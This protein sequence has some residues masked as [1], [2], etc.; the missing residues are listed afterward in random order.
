MFHLNQSWQLLRDFAFIIVSLKKKKMRLGKVN[1]LRM[2]SVHEWRLQ[3]S[4]I[5]SLWLSA[6]ITIYYSIASWK[7]TPIVHDGGW[8]WR[9]QACMGSNL[10]APFSPD[11]HLH[12][13]FSFSDVILLMSPLPFKPPKI[14]FRKQILASM[15]LAG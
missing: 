3:I 12:L 15:S 13:H 10:L 7:I 11:L 9:A 14:K 5:S 8:N 1:L 4:Y 2:H 6:S